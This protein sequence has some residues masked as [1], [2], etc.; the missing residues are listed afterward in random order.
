MKTRIQKWG[1]SLALRIPKSFANEVG[2]ES[3]ALVELAL[4]NG[5]LVVTP[6]SAPSVTLDGLL[7]GVTAE[8]IHAEVDTGSA[9]GNEVW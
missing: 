9:V 2:L 6:I 8:N 7:A 4:V 5:Q 3:N 1:N